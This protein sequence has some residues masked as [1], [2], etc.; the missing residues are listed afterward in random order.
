MARLLLVAVALLCLPAT[1]GAQPPGPPPGIGPGGRL[2]GDQ[3][4]PPRDPR[5]VEAPRGTAIIRGSVVAAETGSPIRRAQVR[6]TGQGVPGRV[7]TTDE[8]GRFEIKELPASRYSVVASKGGFVSLQYGQRRPSESGTPLD[9]GDGQILDKV[10]IG[11]PRGSVIT[12]RITDEYGEPV[13]NA[14]VSAMRYGYQAGTRRLLPGAGQNS[15]DTTDDQGHFRLFAL[16]PGEYIVSAVLRAAGEVT[17][18]AGEPSGYA[19]TYYPGT[20]NVAEAQRVTVNLGQEAGN[21][22]FA[23]I[24]TRL[25]RVTG[26]VINSQGQPVTNGTVML[27]PANA[28][29][30]AGPMAQMSTTRID[31]GGQFRLTNVVPGRYFAQVRTNR[32]GPGGRGGQDSAGE[33]GR[34]DVTVGAD[35]LDGVVIIT[36]PGARAIGQVVTDTGAPAAIQPQQV[37][38]VAPSAAPDQ[39]LPGGPGANARLNDDWTFELNGLFEPRLIRA[40][41]PLGWTLKSVLLNGQDITDTPLDLPPGQTVSG[42]QVVI[43]DKSTSLSGRVTD[44][45]GAAVTDVTVV[46]L[47]SDDGLWMYQSRFVRTARPDQSGQFQIQGLPPYDRYLAVPVQALE[48]GQAGDPEFLARI[49]SLGTSFSLGEGETRALDLRFRTQ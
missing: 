41:L 28:R 8:R 38:I 34:L 48:N 36:G 7:A 11:L 42:L 40:G 22:T 19:P 6:L 43:T 46:I 12:G 20:P 10:V 33:F 18:P 47:P 25:V 14:V 26:A 16:S 4:M 15:R 32:G 29:L 2:G 35:D 37:Q 13:A 1:L 24:A 9:L 21:V 31:G 5:Q 3:R 17:D 44:T 27:A 49:R 39:G 30:G 45:R 23:L